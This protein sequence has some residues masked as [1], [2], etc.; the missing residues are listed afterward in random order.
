MDEVEKSKVRLTYWIDH[1]LDHIRGYREVADIMEREG[2]YDACESIRSGMRLIEEAN[3]EFTR[4]LAMIARRSKKGP[5]SDKPISG[6]G[7]SPSGHHHD[8]HH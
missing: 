1:N 3:G 8:H 6:G 4:A 5:D 7:S 2:L